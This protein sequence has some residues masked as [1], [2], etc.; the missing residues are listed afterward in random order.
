MT[1][2]PLLLGHRG[3]RVNTATPENSFAAFDAALAAG[4]DGFEFDVRATADGRAVVVHDP[5]D[6]GVSIAKA[7]R[8][9]LKHLPQLH[10]VLQKYGSRGFL[11]IELKVEGLDRDLLAALRECPPAR[12]YVVSSFLPEVILELRARRSAIPL[13]IICDQ[14]PQLKRGLELPVEYMILQESLVTLA[15]VQEIHRSGRRLMVWTVNRPNAMLRLAKWEV[16][17]IISD[18][19]ALLVRTFSAGAPATRPSP[20]VVKRAT[21]K[22]FGMKRKNGA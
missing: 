19:P 17:G 1:A 21:T 20:K 5:K 7:R 10:Q 9:Q 12:D 13:G 18:D 15:L 14:R 6:R 2:P 3:T 8:G 16:D 4:C 11:D 22:A